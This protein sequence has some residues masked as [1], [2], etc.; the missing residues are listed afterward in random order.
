MRGTQRSPGPPIDSPNNTVG[1]FKALHPHSRLHFMDKTEHLLVALMLLA[2]VI[3]MNVYL[4]MPTN[5][6]QAL[7]EEFT[8][9]SKSHKFELIPPIQSLKKGLSAS[10]SN[11]LKD[12]EYI[13]DELNAIGCIVLKIRNCFLSLTGF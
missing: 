2:E 8:Q 12:F 10:L 7:G 6:L 5:V 9:Y 1:L 4:V 11:Y 3:H 13:C